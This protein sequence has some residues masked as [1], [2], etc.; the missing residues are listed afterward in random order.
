MVIGVMIISLITGPALSRELA[1]F[2]IRR[3]LELFQMRPF[4]EPANLGRMGAIQY[5]KAAPSARRAHYDRILPFPGPARHPYERPP[6]PC[7]T[8]ERRTPCPPVRRS[9][10]PFCAALS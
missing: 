4:A 3:N 9:A 6:V 1:F 8:A 5:R 10:Y 7:H 2:F